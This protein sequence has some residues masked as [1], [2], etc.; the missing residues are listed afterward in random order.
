M[1]PICGAFNLVADLKNIRL[2][3]ILTYLYLSLYRVSIRWNNNGSILS[4]RC[5]NRGSHAFL[6]VIDQWNRS[7]T[8]SRR[9][10]Y[11]GGAKS[12]ERSNAYLRRRSENNKS[13]KG[14]FRFYEWLLNDPMG[15][16]SSCKAPRKYAILR[17]IPIA[18]LLLAN[19][20]KLR[21]TTHGTHTWRILKIID[22]DNNLRHLL[23][24]V[25]ANSR[26]ERERHPTVHAAVTHIYSPLRRII[27]P[28]GSVEQSWRESP[29]EFRWTSPL[30][31]KERHEIELPWTELERGDTSS[32]LLYIYIFRLFNP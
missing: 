15:C 20:S 19:R 5:T 11:L 22:S 13:T 23:F 8:N 27:S 6:R 26:G 14:C 1:A 12:S 18:W 10:A 29:H 31:I 9:L 30:T 2:E 4:Y 21:T 17:T 7:L 28:L 32:S 25:S 3:N 16:L 24:N